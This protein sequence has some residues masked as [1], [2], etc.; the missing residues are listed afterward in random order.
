[1]H[2]S[3]SR[4]TP[5]QTVNAERRNIS[6]PTKYIDVT[7]TTHTSLDV[8]MEKHIEDYRNV[9]GEK[10]LTDA[11]TGFTRFILLNEKPSD[12]YTWSGWRLSRKQTTSRP[13]DVWP[14]L[15]K[16]MSDTSKKRAK[17][18]WTIE[19][20]NLDNARQLRGI[21]FIEPDDEEFKLTMKAARRK[22]EVLMPAAMPC[23]IPIKNSGK[24]HRNIGKRRTKFACFV[25]ADESSRPRL[26]RAGHKPH[27]DHIT[28]KGTNSMAH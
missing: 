28:A 18:R 20:P 3:S 2:L 8:M 7:R 1:M 12:W 24:T 17:Q 15:R 19:K 10:E 13:E 5:S 21:Y 11:W 27:Q 26:E 9:D 4:C 25:D 14:D 16:H 6:I 22:L 23:K